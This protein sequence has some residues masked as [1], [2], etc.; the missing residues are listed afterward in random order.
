[1][2][3]L[4]KKFLESTGVSTDTRSDLKEKLFFALKGPNFNANTFAHQALENGAIGVVVDEGEY[5]V[6]DKCILVE[7]SLK[8]LQNLANYHRKQLSIPFIAIGGSNG[9]TTTKELTGAVLAKKFKTFCTKGNLNNHIGVPLTLLSIDESIEIAVIELGANHLEETAFL[10][11]IAEPDFGIVTNIGLDHLEGFGSFEGVAKANSELYYY[12]LKKGGNVFVNTTDE[13]L[14]RMTSRFSKPITYPQKTDFLFCE[15]V[16]NELFLE[17]KT[18]GE[19]LI[20]TNLVGEYNT[21][22]IAAALC[23]AKYFGVDLDLACKAIEEYIP[24]NNR[25]QVVK[26]DTNTIILDC[27]NANPSSMEVSVGNFGKINAAHKMLIL[28]DMFELGD[29]SKEEHFKLGKITEQFD[30]EK[31]LLC[32]TAMQDA[33][34]AN[35]NALYF[36]TKDKLNDYLLANKFQNFHILLKGSRGMKLETLVDTL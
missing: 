14:I 15:T 35:N 11:E 18:E 27:Y 24:Q 30:F 33:K 29:V 4:Y 17:V 20:K 22:N 10:C 3:N 13:H 6:S 19:R 21:I 7:D 26:K 16:G 12:L 8:A 36:D 25:S 34:N 31:V 32:G 5:A 9:K 1:M 28:G 2:E 23:I